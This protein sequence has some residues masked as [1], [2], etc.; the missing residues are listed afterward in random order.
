MKIKRPLLAVAAICAS[1]AVFVSAQSEPKIV[2]ATTAI[3]EAFRSHD[4]VMLGEMH[5]NQQEYDWLRDLVA[6]P[7]FADTVDDIVMEFGNSRYQQA[8]DR[9]VS[10]ENVPL[11][12]VQ[13][14]WR[15]TVA[16]VGPPSPV[17]A[18]LYRAVREANLKRTGKH[19]IRV[20][21]GDPP[22]NWQQI[23]EGSDIVPFLRTREQSY[24]GIVEKEVIARH[25]HALLIMGA[26]HVL[27]HFPAR[28]QFDIEQQLRNEGAKTYLVV[29]GTSTTGKPGEVDHRFDSWPVPSIVALDSNWV[30]KL[31]ALPVVTG[32]HAPPLAGSTLEQS[33]DALLYVGSPTSLSIVHMPASELAGTPYGA[34]LERRQKLQMSLEK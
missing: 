34:E 7:K 14:A 19:R 32:G 18:S 10:G 26:F 20:L 4:L 16:S 33:A 24:A 11:E 22:I 13:G 27:R 23:K 15:D 17:Y 30:G 31:A 28:Q 12:E 5:G 1:T 29:M 6:N 9:Y 2:N 8:V 3:L 25:H 21:C